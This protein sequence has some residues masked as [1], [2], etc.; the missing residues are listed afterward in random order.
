MEENKRQ[1][2]EKNSLIEK[3]K[4]LLFLKMS[5]YNNSLKNHALIKKVRKEIAREATLMNTERKA[6]N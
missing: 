5:V 4:L 3:K 1:I 2:Q 6:K